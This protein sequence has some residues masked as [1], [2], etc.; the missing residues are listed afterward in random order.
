MKNKIGIC[1]ATSEDYAPLRDLHHHSIRCNPKGFIQDLAHHGCLV[2]SLRRWR[3]EGGDL[4]V[5]RL[6]G[7]VVG[8]GGLAPLGKGCVELC[9][10]HVRPACQGLGVGRRLVETLIDRARL[11]G[12]TRIELHVTATQKAAIRLYER[13]AFQEVKRVIHRVTVFG[14]EVLFDTLYMALPLCPARADAVA[15]AAQT[16]GSVQELS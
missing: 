12:F 5:A 6:D 10:L 16:P 2:E 8:L 9:K 3:R 13:L 14:D 7:Q 15:I 1:S 4:L 11:R